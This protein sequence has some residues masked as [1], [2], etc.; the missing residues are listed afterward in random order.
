M[1]KCRFAEGTECFKETSGQTVLQPI[2]SPPWVQQ[3]L[4]SGAGIV[5]SDVLANPWPAGL[6][7]PAA[8]PVLPQI[9][10]FKG[11]YSASGVPLFVTAAGTPAVSQ[12]LYGFTRNLRI[13]YVQQWNL[14]T[15]YEFLKG[16]VAEIG[17]IGSHGVALLVE[18]SLNM[19]QLVNA[20]NPGVDGLTVNSNT[21][22]TI[23]VPV[24]GFAPAGLNLVTNQGFSSYNAAILEVKH[25][26]SNSF[27]FRVDYTYSHSI[28]NDLAPTGSDLDS[29]V[30]NQENPYLA[31]ARLRL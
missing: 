31:R 16:W 10:Q 4:A 15:Q 27:Q 30:G 13:P 2:S 23:R 12:S 29:F 28:D 14:S 24:L 5:G 22:A 17:Y 19:A 1:A 20:A 8:F 11:N 26:F 6:P 7:L 25:D 3:Y 9:G 18:P 21:N